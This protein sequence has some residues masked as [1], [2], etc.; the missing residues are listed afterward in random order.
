MA[1]PN[2]PFYLL[3]LTLLGPSR[4]QTRSVA[5]V[6]ASRAFGAPGIHVIRHH[7]L[8]ATVG[9]L[10]TKLMLIVR[11]AVFAEAM[12]AFLGLGTNDVLS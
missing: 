10:P 3:A 4:I 2:I 11:F 12:L 9:V 8:P 6:E 7:L 5:Y 1:L